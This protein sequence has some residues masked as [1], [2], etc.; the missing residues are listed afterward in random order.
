[1]LELAPRRAAEWEEAGG[2]VILLRP[3]PR[4]R[5]VRGWLDGVFHALSAGRIRLDEVGSFAWL[6]F[7]GRRTVA[8]V[9]TLMTQEFGD[10]VDPVEERL[11]HHVWT[12]R[13]EGFLVYPE[14]DD[15]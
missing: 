7:D 15:V 5:G 4:T 6:S 1:M 9:A 8:E 3:R 2:R 11:A 13:K 14:W 10:Q 12:L